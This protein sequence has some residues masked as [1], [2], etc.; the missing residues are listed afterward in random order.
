MRS[1]IKIDKP[2]NHIAN[3]ISD[4]NI[5]EQIEKKVDAIMNDC[6]NQTNYGKSDKLPKLFGHIQSFEFACQNYSHT[7]YNVL[8]M[9]I[10]T[11][12]KTWYQH[13]VLR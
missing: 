7:F 3:R 8:S 11:Q 9:T 2:G 13:Y 12:Q 5:D 1:Q 6:G 10:F 4:I